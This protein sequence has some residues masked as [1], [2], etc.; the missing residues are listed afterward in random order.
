MKRVGK[1]GVELYQSRLEGVK[2]EADAPPRLNFW[3]TFTD[4]FTTLLSERQSMTIRDSCWMN[5]K[6]LGDKS[7]EM[8]PDTPAIRMKTVFLLSCLLYGESPDK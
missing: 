7:V 4:A 2:V 8:K 3:E 5:A 1:Q 6:T